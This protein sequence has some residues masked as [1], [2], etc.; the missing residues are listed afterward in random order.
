MSVELQNLLITQDTTIF[1]SESGAVAVDISSNTYPNIF[2]NFHNKLYTLIEID[3]TS[4]I[5]DLFSL[6]NVTSN[7]ILQSNGKITLEA[8]YRPNLGIITELLY[9]YEDDIYKTY[10]TYENITT[11]SNN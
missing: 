2:L 8:E 6:K 4:S 9:S 7:I 3:Y 11:T 10:Y 1:D 5:F